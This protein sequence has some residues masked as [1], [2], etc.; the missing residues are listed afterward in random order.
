VYRRL[1]GGP[2]PLGGYVPDGDEALDDPTDYKVF[3]NKVF[4][5]GASR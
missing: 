2:Q 5:E 4:A 3:D 1:H